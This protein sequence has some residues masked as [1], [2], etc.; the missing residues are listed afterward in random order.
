[1]REDVGGARAPRAEREPARIL[2][3][4]VEG[5]FDLDRVATEAGGELFRPLDRDDGVGVNH[6]F[7]A[8][9]GNVGGAD[10]I[11]INMVEGDSAGVLV[12][13]SEAGTG[14]G[15]GNSEALGQALDEGGLAGAEFAAQ[16]KEVAWLEAGGEG[17]PDGLSFLGGA[18]D[19]HKSLVVARL[20]ES[21]AP[22]RSGR[23]MV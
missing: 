2:V 23:D 4:L 18:R 11:E 8:D 19:A 9:V 7:D 17:S 5:D 21:R 13:E 3:G 22:T 16:A 10:A 15:V 6:L 20:Q 12:D 14:D 1:M